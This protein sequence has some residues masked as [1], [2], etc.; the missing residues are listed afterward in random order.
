MP[1]RNVALLNSFYAAYEDHDS[2][3]LADLLTEDAFVL[4]TAG[5]SEHH[6]GREAV[7]A[8]FTEI[9]MQAPDTFD[10]DIHDILANDHYGLVIVKVTARRGDHQYSEWETHVHE[11]S[12]GLSAGIFVYWNDP[13]PANEFFGRET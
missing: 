3:R 1:Q 7:V 10:L 4:F 6:R 2:G 9:W 11:L 13:E 5:P 8:A 12:D